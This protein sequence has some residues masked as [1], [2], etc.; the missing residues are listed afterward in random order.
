MDENKKLIE[1]E[2][3]QNTPFQLVK[4]ENMYYI[5]LAGHRASIKAFALKREALA[6]IN[7]KPWE[8]IGALTAVLVE[9]FKESEIIREKQNINNKN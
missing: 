1:F 6:Y 5:C 4:T 7:K 8:L 9:K 3:V 2:N